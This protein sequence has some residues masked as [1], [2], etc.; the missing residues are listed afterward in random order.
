M[1]LYAFTWSFGGS[2][3]NYKEQNWFSN[4]VKET[5]KCEIAKADTIFD[6]VYDNGILKNV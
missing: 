1:F 2:F 4:L 6:L 3:H 5:C